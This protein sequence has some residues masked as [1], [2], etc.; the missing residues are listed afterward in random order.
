MKY[1][2]MAIVHA[3]CLFSTRRS[4]DLDDKTRRLYPKIMQQE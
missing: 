2:R 1:K 4:S 3:R